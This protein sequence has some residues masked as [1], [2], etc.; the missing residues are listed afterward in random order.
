MFRGTL[1]LTQENHHFIVQIEK[2]IKCSQWTKL[3]RTCST[4]YYTAHNNLQIGMRLCS[5][6]SSRFLFL[7][8][9]SVARCR[10]FKNHEFTYTEGLN[11][12]TEGPTNFINIKF[13]TVLNCNDALVG[14]A[15]NS[16][17][18]SYVHTRLLELGCY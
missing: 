12:L 3:T 6:T 14:V 1:S 5:L 4:S 18:R 13:A 17:V 15:I 8:L 11:I 9:V 10:P 16:S 7:L 2:K